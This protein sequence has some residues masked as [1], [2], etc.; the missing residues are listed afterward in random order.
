VD[1]VLVTGVSGPIGAALL[2]YLE[3]QGARIVRLVRGP[4]R[5]PDQ[6]SWD[7]LRPLDPAVV[8]GFEA[9]INLAGESVTGRWTAAKKKAIRESRVL[10]TTHLATALARTPLRPRL[11]LCASA[12]GFFGN[13]GD[14]VL[15]EA[16]VSGEGFLP[17]VCR[18]WEAASW[19]AADGGIRTV[20][21]RFGLVLS[22]KGG[23]LGKMLMPFKLGVGGRIGSG[24]QWWSW[25]HIDDIV[26]AVH[27]ALQSNALSGPFN[28]VAPNPA[29]N[30]EFTEVLASILH[31]PAVFPVPPLALR[32]AFGKMA[33]AELFLSS[34]R[35]MPAKLQE[36]G[37]AFR[38]PN[39]R[40][41]LEELLG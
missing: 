15:T 34:E 27:H 30:V 9:V 23:A 11:F 14:E 5:G 20:N 7:P 31:R 24:Q 25:V 6:I 4:A 16:S 19:I 22:P 10:G 2:P 13:R 26:G 37:Y 8:S 40:P 1:R 17:E 33:A 28:M 29:R 35:V 38:F 3:S 36:T 18:E 12:I 32:L 21:I 39:L 41:A